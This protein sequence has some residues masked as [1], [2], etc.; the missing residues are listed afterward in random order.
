ME[1]AECGQCIS[2]VKVPGKNTQYPGG[3]KCLHRGP[4]YPDAAYA[5]PFFIYSEVADKEHL[6]G[7]G[8]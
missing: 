6:S 4:M 3:C 7:G 2:C 8:Q 1:R 5:C